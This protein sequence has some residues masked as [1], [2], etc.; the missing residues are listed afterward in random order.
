[1]N[2]LFTK[3]DNKSTDFK[4][5]QHELQ[6]SKSLN[7][8][9]HRPNSMSVA[10]LVPQESAI[11]K[12]SLKIELSRTQTE[13]GVF[14]TNPQSTKLAPA[15]KEYKS[16]LG[17]QFSLSQMSKTTKHSELL[18]SINLGDTFQQNALQKRRVQYKNLIAR[19]NKKLE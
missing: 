13:P 7:G 4:F 1:M 18:N 14:M 19:L 8:N 6:R 15:F 10:K 11:P 2:K 16:M 12:P 17:H 5:K 9:I 3:S